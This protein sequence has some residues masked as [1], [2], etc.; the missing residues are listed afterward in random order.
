MSTTAAAQNT[1]EHSLTVY[2]QAGP[3]SV[4]PE[5]IAQQANNPGYRQ[6]IPG[7]AMVRTTRDMDLTKGVSTLKFTDVA[8]GIDASTVKA[9]APNHPDDFRV[10]EQNYVY[11]LVSN[12]RLL[13][14]FIDQTVTIDVPMG[15]SVQTVRGTLLSANEGR[16]ILQ[17]DDGSLISSPYHAGEI[18]FPS[19]PDGLITR[20]TLK[21]QVSSDLAGAEPIQIAYET[22]GMT[23]WSDY[24][25]LLDESDGCKLDVSAWV[26]LVNM[27]GGSFPQAKLKLI[28][29]EVNRAPQPNVR[30]KHLMQRMDVAASSIPEESFQEESFFEYHLY[31]LP[32]RT[33]VPDRS[34]KQIELF[35]AAHD[36][37]CEKELVFSAGQ[38]GLYGRGSPYLN[39]A[40]PTSRKGDVLVNIEF[41]NSEDNNMGM[42]LPAGRVRVS[43]RNPNDGNLEFIGEDTIDHTPRN[44][45]LSIHI[46][47]AFDVVGERTQVNFRWNKDEKWME[48]TME[49]SVRNRKEDQSVTVDIRESLYRWTNWEIKD[50]SHKHK[51]LDATTVEFPVTIEPDGEAKVRYV[52]RYTW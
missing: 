30:S 51:K 10:L 8:Q 17:K 2:S 46:G 47:K 42:P 36:V 40:N 33:D 1:D 28:A 19:L 15:D 7:Y 43:Q 49:I 32:R 27:S 4:S 16:L 21:W 3:G 9:T 22:K 38:V 24:N 35:P 50:A 14:R 26:T 11:D 18:R 45:K 41:E 13:Q 31:T 44:E 25:L 37:Q 39:T 5:T 29:G 34:M 48:E 6:N 52:A 23:W 20:P 12:E